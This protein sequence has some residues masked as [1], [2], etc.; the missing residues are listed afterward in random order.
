MTIDI[1]EF[2]LRICFTYKLTNGRFHSF[3]LANL[4]LDLQENHHCVGYA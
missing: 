1:I 2:A 4:I 3:D